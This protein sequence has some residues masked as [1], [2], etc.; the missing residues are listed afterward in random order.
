MAHIGQ[1][2]AYY[3]QLVERF[4]A[5]LELRYNDIHGRKGSDR[6]CEILA[7]L[8]DGLLADQVSHDVS[9][10]NLESALRHFQQVRHAS[11]VPGKYHEILEL[12][13]IDEVKTEGYTPQLF[14]IV[15]L[16]KHVTH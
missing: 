4:Y 16:D 7:K 2:G 8:L 15:T 9:L 10:A 11:F 3:T 1:F 14:G 6:E 5:A 12:M 13:N